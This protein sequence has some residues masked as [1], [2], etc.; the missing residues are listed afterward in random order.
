MNRRVMRACVDVATV[1]TSPHAPRG[2]DAPAIADRPDVAGWL[3]GLGP[4]GR[5]GL[6]GRTLTQLVAGE[7]VQVVDV[8]GDWSRV[9]ALWQPNPGDEA[10][11][12]GW[13]RRAHLRPENADDPGSPA[14]ELPA[15]PVALLDA[16]RDHLGLPYLWGGTSP[17]GMDCSGLVHHTYRRAGVVVPR[18]ASA[19]RE[20]SVPVP[21]GEERAGDLYFFGDAAAGITHVGFVVTAGRLLH[22]PEDGAEPGGGVVVEEPL[23]ADLESR[24]IAAGRFLA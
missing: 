5:L 11:Y 1:W 20:G 9:A 10:G 15:D 13:V 14:V 12:V 19:Q 21:F 4:P 23:T 2:V 18:D 3:A 8:D 24:L 7:P 16:A 6:H 17:A 22:A